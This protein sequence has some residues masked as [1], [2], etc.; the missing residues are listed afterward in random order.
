MIGKKNMIKKK[1]KKLKEVEQQ[2]EKSQPC[3]NILLV[4]NKL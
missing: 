4:A 2:K 1:A 3:I